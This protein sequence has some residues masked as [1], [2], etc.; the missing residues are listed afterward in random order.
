MAKD[1]KYYFKKAAKEGWAM[2]QFNFSTLEQ[3]R[4]IFLAAEKLQAPTILGTSEKESLFFGIAEAVALVRIFRKRSGL[5]IFLNLDHGKD[6]SYLKR[7]AD[8]GYDAVHFDGSQLPLREN[9]KKTAQLVEYC[10]K[11][12]VLVEGEVGVLAGSGKN[13]LGK[14]AVAE[15]SLTRPQEAAEFVAKTKVDS[16]AISVGNV[17]GVYRQMPQI[18]YLR[19]KEIKKTIKAFLVF[20]GGSGFG[21]KEITAAIKAGIVKININT[22]LRIAWRT[23]LERSLRQSQEIKPYNLLLSVSEAVEKTVEDKIRLFHSDKKL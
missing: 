9:I 20:H 11:K 1:L 5:P 19:I 7:V 15:K 14:I 13:D 10:C 17:H 4:A 8:F 3:L 22:E 21:S 12:G 18:D 6:L 23:A 2:G 16:L